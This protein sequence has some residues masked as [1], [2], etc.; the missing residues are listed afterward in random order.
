MLFVRVATA[1]Y[2]SADITKTSLFQ[3][4]RRKNEIANHLADTRR[5]V[6][7]RDASAVWCLLG[8]SERG[9]TAAVF[10]NAKPNLLHC[11][12]KLRTAMRW[13]PP[14]GELMISSPVG[15]VLC[16]LH[17]TGRSASRLCCD[18]HRS[19][20]AGHRPHRSVIAKSQPLPPREL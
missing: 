9:K 18:W 20:A 8:M 14:T 6:S 2:R 13:A 15:F 7:H 17:S 10:T 5:D 1:R 19:L 12:D 11:Q 4:Q 3:G 16:S